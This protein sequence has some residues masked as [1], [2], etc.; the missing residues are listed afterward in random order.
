MESHS[1]P[2]GGELQPEDKCGLDGEVVRDVVEDGTEGQ[3]LKEGEE[4]EDGPVGQPL[5]I[6]LGSRSLDGA[7]GEIS[8]ECPSDEVGDRESESVDE[9]GRQEED[10]SD[11]E[12]SDRAER[13]EAREEEDEE[14]VSV[15]KID[16]MALSQA[17]REEAEREEIELSK[18]KVVYKV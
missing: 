4:T 1:T 16:K 13:G 6:I 3:A 17:D 11:E 9:D 18:D 8:G 14:V 10:S 12:V 2:G 7:E 5:H 15:P